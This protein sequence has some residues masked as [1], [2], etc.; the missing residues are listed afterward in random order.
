MENKLALKMAEQD[1]TSFDFNLMEIKLTSELELQLAQLQDLEKERANIGNP[2]ALSKVVMN[3]VWNQFSNQIGLDLTDETLIQEYDREYMEQHGKPETYEDAGK[4]AMADQRYK[5]ANKQMKKDQESGNLTDAYTGKKLKQGDK[6]NLDHVVSRKE[7]YENVRRKQAKRSTADLANKDENLKP[8]NEA[9]NKSKGKKSVDEYTNEDKRKQREADLVKNNEK[10]NKK[11]D[12][13]NMSEADKKAAKAKNNKRLQDK[14]NADS[15]KMK[16]ADKEARSAIN[17]EIFI[18]ASKEIGKKAVK[19]AAKTM[20]VSSLFTLLKEIMNGFVRF[21]KAKA[22]SFK[23]FMDEIKRSI[24][25]FFK[26]L[27]SIFKT[28]ANSALGTI[29]AEILDPIIGMFKKFASLIRQGV[30]SFV[31]AIKYLTSSENKNKPFSE[32]VAQVGKIIVGGIT[33]SSA[34][35]LG[36]VLEKILL[37]VPFMQMVIPLVGTLANIVGMFIASV[38]CGV[39][40]AI[41][42]NRIDKFLAERQKNALVI[43]EIEKKNDIIIT[44]NKLIIND[45]Q[46]IDYVKTEARDSMSERH[47]GL[48]ETIKES[49]TN[50][51][52]EN[53]V[54]K[55]LDTLEDIKKKL[56]NIGNKGV[57]LSE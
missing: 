7:I 20:M 52:G 32:K 35:V 37:T 27:S 6:A 11:I 8:T 16:A 12:E 5:D 54:D 46:K 49:Y 9:L 1:Y 57:A 43:R 33:A 31:D 17:K 44:Q 39:I 50:A 18:G 55:D 40:G 21:M 2:D 26:K 3:E 51:F 24:K 4:E 47:S 13:S 22:K 28:G 38:V 45:I 36:E 30:S 48:V 34:I 56:N 15:E 41:A 29:V 53:G 14:L 23:V 10:A 19:D 42:I 25:N